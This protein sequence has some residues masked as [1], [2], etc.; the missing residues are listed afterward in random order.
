MG[1]SDDCRATRDRSAV[2]GRI[3][4]S[5]IRHRAWP[6]QPA[7]ASLD[8][9]DLAAAHGIT[10]PDEPPHVRYSRRVDVRAWWPRLA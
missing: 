9:T 10:L 5:E 2:D 7:A 3:T 4:R 6:L 8:A 1:W